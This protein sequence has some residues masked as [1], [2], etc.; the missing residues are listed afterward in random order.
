[1]SQTTEEVVRRPMARRAT[2]PPQDEVRHKPMAH[3]GMLTPVV[4][5]ATAEQDPTAEQADQP[6]QG[7]D[8]YAAPRTVATEGGQG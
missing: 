6:E 4:D 5:D 3:E 8:E 1:M 7:G 2:E